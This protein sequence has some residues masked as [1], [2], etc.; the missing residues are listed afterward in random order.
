MECGALVWSFNAVA[1]IDWLDV[2]RSLAPVATAVIAFVALKNWQR[3][4]RAK[5]QAEFLDDL[6]AA[7][8]A[9]VVEVQKPIEWFHGAKIGM[10]SHVNSWEEGTDEEK[11]V[12]GAI[13][14][15]QANGEKDGNR[16]SAALKELEPAVVKLRSLA[17]KGQVFKFHDYAKCQKA[18]EQLT[19]QAGRMQAFVAIAG[20]PTWNWENPEVLSLLKNVMAIEPDEIRESIGKSDVAVIQFVQETYGRIYG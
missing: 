7:S 19:W 10:A 12:R 8:H 13:A 6:I 2:I 11:S 3:Q 15:I 9:Y 17:S 20:W 16:I 1:G 18:V 14:Y 5:R 4:D